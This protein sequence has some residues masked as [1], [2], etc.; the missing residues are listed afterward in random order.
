MVKTKK[1]GDF[2]LA[3]QYDNYRHTYV[4]AD[5]DLAD[6]NLA[7]VTWDRQTAKFNSRQIFRLYSIN[8]TKMQAYNDNLCL[9]LRLPNLSDYSLG[10][11]V[12][13]LK[14]LTSLCGP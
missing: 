2:Y 14:C 1:L 8:A 3:V 4:H 7:V 13:L 12:R 5:E 6:F 10:K 9:D 11:I